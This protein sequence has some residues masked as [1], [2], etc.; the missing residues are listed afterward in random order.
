MRRAALLA[1][2]GWSFWACDR[3]TETECP[4]AA[5]H[6]T[7]LLEL[8]AQTDEPLVLPTDAVRVPERPGVF[9]ITEQTGRVWE[10]D[11]GRGERRVVL[12]LSGEVARF[13]ENWELGLYAVTV[14]PDFPT[15][16][17]V[18]VSFTA[19]SGGG[20]RSRIVEY[21]LGND[22]VWDPATRRVIFERG[23]PNPV[24]NGGD[25]RFLLD[26]RLGYALGDGDESG[27]SQDEDDTLGKFMA[28]DVDTGAIQILAVG[29]RN[30]WRWAV[31]PFDGQVFV[32]DVGHFDREEINRLVS[33]GNFGWPR[34]QGTE[35]DRGEP[36]CDECG[37][38]QPPV[39]EYC[40]SEGGAV[41]AGLFYRGTEIPALRGQFIYG[42]FRDGTLF[43]L[44]PDAQGPTGPTIIGE[45]SANV[46]AF[47]EDHDNEVLAISRSSGQIL[48]LAG[49]DF[50]D[51][52]PDLLSE[53]DFVDPATPTEPPPDAVSYSVNH[54]FFSDGAGKARWLIPAPGNPT[55]ETL[56]DGRLN[57]P[58]GSALVK[59]FEIDG[60]PVETQVYRHESD[61]QWRGYSYRWQDDG[62]DA[63][64][65]QLGVGPVVLPSIAVATPLVVR[66]VSVD[67]G[68]NRL[69]IYF[70]VLYQCAADR[71]VQTPIVEGLDCGVARRR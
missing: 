62:T 24:H 6:P 13:E 11:R 60:Q 56:D 58:I 50:S 23:Q 63:G 49:V 28:I 46:T 26:G 12:D 66:L 65:Q 71:R 25:I 7:L 69:T 51:D 52:P 14:H 18:Y 57:P 2:A 33:P 29:F 68:F 67:P 43:V 22:G 39:V 42:D 48:A 31:S 16:D 53:T 9:F 64:A 32:G 19:G 10:L 40:R 17:R 30:P 20:I 47:F 70:K 61:D 41:V 27:Q 15:D 5:L 37:P 55:I 4:D 59:Y 38:L 3:R 36:F 54:P 8:R 21:R 34:Y 44:A 45:T 35:P 1:A